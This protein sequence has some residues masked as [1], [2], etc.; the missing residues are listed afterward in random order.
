MR[1]THQENTSTLENQTPTLSLALKRYMLRAI[2]LLAPVAIMSSTV[3]QPSAVNAEAAAQTGPSRGRPTLGLS[4]SHYFTGYGEVVVKCSGWV[5]ARKGAQQNGTVAAQVCVTNGYEEYCSDQSGFTQ[6][7][8]RATGVGYFPDNDEYFT[9]YLLQTFDSG[10]AADSS[11]GTFKAT[12][13]HS[14]GYFTGN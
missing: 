2:T 7:T 5:R 14:I 13:V 9:A 4:C 1:I 10:I 11:G 8:A 6:G 12:D 3:L